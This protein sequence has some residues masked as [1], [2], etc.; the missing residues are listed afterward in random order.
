MTL[1][2]RSRWIACLAPLIVI[3]SFA[4]SNATLLTFDQDPPITDFET[5]DESYGD[6]VTSTT[7][8]GNYLYGEMGEGFTPN[9]VIDY[10]PDPGADPRLWSTGYGDLSNVLFENNDAFGILRLTFTADTGFVVRLHSWDI[11]AYT[12]SFASDPTIDYVRVLDSDGTELYRED[13][14]SISRT[15]HTTFDFSA[16][17]FTDD[18]LVL[19]YSSNNLTGQTDSIASDNFRFS[20]AAAVPE[21]SI[22][23]IWTGLTAIGGATAIIRRK[24]CRFSRP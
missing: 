15:T 22:L 2:H 19:E 16:T 4:E 3:A 7:M 5:L 21:A 13:S 14:K 12:T 11:I 17:P 8:P 6:R 20:Q 18:V 24:R 1:P 23:F 9:V 10:G